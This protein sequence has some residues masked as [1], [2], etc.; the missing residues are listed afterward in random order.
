MYIISFYLYFIVSTWIWHHLNRM[1]MHL[2][3]NSSARTLHSA[4]TFNRTCWQRSFSCLPDS[5]IAVRSWERLICS[6]VMRMSPAFSRT[7]WLDVKPVA[8]RRARCGRGCCGRGC[9]WRFLWVTRLAARRVSDSSVWSRPLLGRQCVLGFVSGILAW[10]VDYNLCSS[11]L[12]SQKFGLG[13]WHLW[14][15]MYVCMSK[16]FKLWHHEHE[17]LSSAQDA[18]WFGILWWPP[19]KV[20]RQK[21]Q[22]VCFGAYHWT[23]IT[24][25]RKWCSAAGDLRSYAKK[26]W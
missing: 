4:S 23:L 16:C 9:N 10:A 1:I 21:G 19:G 17:I 6:R 8:S 7:S 11:R 12:L 25:N 26:L 18:I 5:S 2:Q 13:N 3:R 15:R 22:H 14:I 20:S 24:I